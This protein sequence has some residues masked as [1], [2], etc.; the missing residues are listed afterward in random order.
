LP[1]R[2]AVISAVSP[3]GSG[4]FAS[5]PASSNSSIIAALPLTAAE[6]SGVTPYRFAALTLAPARISSSA[7]VTSSRSVAQCSA[8]VPSA[9]LT[10]TE[11]GCFKRTRTA[12]ASPRLT[13]SRSGDLAPAAPSVL[14][15]TATSSVTTDHLAIRFSCMVSPVSDV[16]RKAE[17]LRYRS[18]EALRY[19]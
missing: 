19:R 5:A 1:V 16:L 17:A 13:A 18:A 2:A 11:P 3:S 10:F 7:V 8:V 15:G 12:V 9:S 14:A 6:Y 4:V